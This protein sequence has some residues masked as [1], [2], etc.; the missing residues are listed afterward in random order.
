M[1]KYKY[2]I[3]NTDKQE[4]LWQIDKFE[5]V[6]VFELQYNCWHKSANDYQFMTTS[7]TIR[8]INKREARSLFPN[9]FPSAK[10]ET[11]I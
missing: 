2:F 9:A 3:C 8:Q 11:T 1:I 4:M 10:K 7:D 5:Y 6:E